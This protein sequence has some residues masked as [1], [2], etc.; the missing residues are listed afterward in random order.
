M[1]ITE[2][3]EEMR[4]I[5]AQ[6]LQD[7]HRGEIDK[8]RESTSDLAAADLFGAKI[9]E[10]SRAL[11]DLAPDGRNKFYTKLADFCTPLTLTIIAGPSE[12]ANIGSISN[13]GRYPELEIEIF[14]NFVSLVDTNEKKHYESFD[15]PDIAIEAIKRWAVRNAPG[16][17]LNSPPKAENSP[18]P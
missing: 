1:N 10:F 9:I 14:R 4:G 11:E 6:N 18:R 5:A 7:K 3:F 12:N 2:H 13:G 16:V 17:C 15:S 8:T